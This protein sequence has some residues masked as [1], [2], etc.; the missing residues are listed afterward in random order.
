MKK[1]GWGNSDKKS[2]VESTFSPEPTES[3]DSEIEFENTSGLAKKY[4]NMK[5]KDL[6]RVRGGV[7]G[8][9]E[10]VG[11]LKNLT[12]TANQ[13]Q[14][15]AERR[16]ELVEKDFIISNVKKYID[17]S[18]SNHFDAIE[19]QKKIITALYKADP[20]KAE[21]KVE[22]LRKKSITKISREAIKS[23]KNSVTG[24]KKKYDN[25]DINS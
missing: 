8:L 25:D 12:A 15:I 22:E 3:D 19:S 5:I 23:I 24:L 11:I 1:D 9:K 10:W 14:I 21:T 7:T 20:D 4:L 2:T 17:L 13:E 6:V 16:N 18:L